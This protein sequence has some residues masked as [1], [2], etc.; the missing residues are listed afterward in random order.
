MVSYE[1]ANHA[2]GAD[3]EQHTPIVD[4]LM[5]TW[6][7][8]Q[9]DVHGGQLGAERAAFIGWTALKEVFSAWRITEREELTKWLRSHGFAGRQP[10]NH[11]SARAQEYILNVARRIDARVALLEVTYVAVVFFVARH[12]VPAGV[13]TREVP[14][15]QGTH[16]VSWNNTG[17]LPSGVWVQLDEVDAEDFFLR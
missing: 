17:G 16:Q 15:A 14:R 11:I 8:P 12:M 13:Q 10:G 2:G 4:W 7:A 9:V 3:Q 1:R 5:L 6:S